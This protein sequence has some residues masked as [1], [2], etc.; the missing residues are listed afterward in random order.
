[1]SLLVTVVDTVIK[2]RFS[3]IPAC[4]E[5]LWHNDSGQAGMTIEGISSTLYTDTN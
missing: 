1:M 3:V 4:P 5:S 2:S